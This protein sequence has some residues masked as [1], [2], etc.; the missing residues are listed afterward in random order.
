MPIL[1]VKQDDKITTV[2]FEKGTLL[3]DL[4]V[5]HGFKVPHLCGGRGK[6]GKCAVDISGDISEETDTEREFGKR[7]SC[8]TVLY[9]DATLEL[10]K[11][12]SIA[13]IDTGEDFE[14]L[15]NMETVSRLG[16]A[17]D[18]GTTTIAMKLCDLTNDRIIDANAV[19]NPQIT[20]SGDVIGRIALAA[21]G[22]AD[23][24]RNLVSNA[25]ETSVKDMLIKNNF[26]DNVEKTVVTG[27]TSMLYLYTGKDAQ[28]LSVYPFITDELFDFEQT[29]GDTDSYFPPCV[30]AFAGADLLCA[31]LASGMTDKN[32]I[33]LLCDIG[34]NNEIA[35]YKDG[36]LTVTST[37]AG[38]V[39]EGAGIT[40]GCMGIKGA[41]DKVWL[42]N[43]ILNIHTIEEDIPCGI[44]GSGVIDSVAV[45]LKTGII[46]KN[47]NL[48]SDICFYNDIVLTQ[49][50]VRAVQLAKSAIL[51][52]IQTLTALCG[53]RCEE[54]KTFY[55][56][57]G[58]GKYINI[59]NAGYIGLF[60]KC[61][62]EKTKILGN[63]ALD[64]AVKLLFDGKQKNKIR[65]IASVCKCVNL[66][67]NENF[68]K[69]YI[70]N[71]SFEEI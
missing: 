49:D 10:K 40:H 14:Y 20:L 33:S 70:K 42:E 15:P 32:E 43:G 68:N 58:F 61:F 65:N 41:I 63:A 3:D 30:S 54:I 1:T 52:G 22:K 27:N 7:L 31:V 44:C 13:N 5:K 55:I 38:P 53:I 8:R 57:G 21:S 59:Q 46:D 26:S 16:V 19:L 18:I 24:L 9:G 69:L 51:S 35:L 47:G 48:S 28:K 50:D 34:T 71:M 36:V 23:L 17:V 62:S 66:G 56:A 6:C 29:L 37:A 12:K 25:V 60:P 4:L 39:F 67:G 2:N 64:G 45:G 11:Q